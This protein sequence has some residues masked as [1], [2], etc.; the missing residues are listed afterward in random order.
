MDLLTLVIIV[1][2]AYYLYQCK[3]SKGESLIPSST[4]ISGGYS[5]ERS[6]GM[7]GGSARVASFTPKTGGR[8][9]VVPMH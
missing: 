8:L 6:N 9:N 3:K 5:D 2:L 7:Y 4:S 1:A